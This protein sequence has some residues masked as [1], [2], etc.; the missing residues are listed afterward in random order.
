MIL[1]FF[2]FMNHKIGCQNKMSGFVPWLMFSV[3]GGSFEA[4]STETRTPGKDIAV[5]SLDVCFLVVKKS[6]PLMDLLPTFWPHY[7]F[8]FFSTMKTKM[9]SA[10]FKFH[11]LGTSTCNP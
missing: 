2:T 8:S 10:K 5:R 9:E 11:F 4:T 6:G 7:Y 1:F 3:P